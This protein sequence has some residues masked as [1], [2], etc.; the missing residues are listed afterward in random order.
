MAGCM[1][2]CGH[3]RAGT[4]NL[5]GCGDVGEADIGTPWGGEYN[6]LARTHCATRRGAVASRR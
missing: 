3:C 1:I 4:R 2:W 6:G 5:R